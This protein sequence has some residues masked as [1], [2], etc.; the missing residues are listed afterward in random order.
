MSNIVFQSTLIIFTYKRVRKFAFMLILPTFTEARGGHCC[1]S[2]GYGGGGEYG[3]DGGDADDD[4]YSGGGGG[5]SHVSEGD[6]SGSNKIMV[7]IMLVLPV[8]V[9]ENDGGR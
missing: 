4:D 1:G 9:G 8:L 3:G 2:C 5:G 6:D 7:V